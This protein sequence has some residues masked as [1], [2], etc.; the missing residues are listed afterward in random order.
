MGKRE[1][2]TPNTAILLLI[3]YYLSLF[4]KEAV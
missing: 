4:N 1:E 2:R 3:T